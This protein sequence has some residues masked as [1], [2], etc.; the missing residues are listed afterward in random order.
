M[1]DEP[2]RR[3]E[4]D[5]SIGLLRTANVFFSRLYHSVTVC[6][7]CRL[8][9]RGAGILVSNH[10]SGVDPALIQSA[11]PRL[12]RWMMAAEYFRVPGMRL[13][14]DNVGTI[15]VDRKGRDTAATR[16]ALRAL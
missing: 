15:L 5:L 10:L 9:P 7:P 1:S 14:F 16:S 8:P 6:S 11:C 13:L 3:T 4:R 2:F 12:I